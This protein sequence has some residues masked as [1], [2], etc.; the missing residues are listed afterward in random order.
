M[1]HYMTHFPANYTKYIEDNYPRQAVGDANG[2]IEILVW[3]Y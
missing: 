3:M 1:P 2:L